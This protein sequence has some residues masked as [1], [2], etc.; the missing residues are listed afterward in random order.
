MDKIDPKVHMKN[1][2]DELKKVE[3]LSGNEFAI[4]VNDI[5]NTFPNNKKEI[6]EYS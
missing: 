4:A 3:S 6:N 1:L 2:S 5:Y